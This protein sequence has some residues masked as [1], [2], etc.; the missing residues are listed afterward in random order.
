[1]DVSPKNDVAPSSTIPAIRATSRHKL[2]PP[3]TDAPVSAIP[4]LSVNSD[5]V[6]EHGV[7]RSAFGVRRSAFGVR[8]SAFSVQ[9]SAFVQRVGGFFPGAHHHPG[10]IPTDSHAIKT[11]GLG[12]R[13][14]VI[15]FERANDILGRAIPEYL[16]TFDRTSPHPQNRQLKL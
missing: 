2:F 14:L 7:G 11:A 8:R 5:S 16:E 6:N 15:F 10:Q 3:K 4:G 9:R 13:E 1:M 12:R